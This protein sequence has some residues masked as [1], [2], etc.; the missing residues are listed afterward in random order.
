MSNTGRMRTSHEVR[1]P[2]Q[3]T[4][5]YTASGPGS[6]L[7][8]A[9]IHGW[10]LTRGDFDE[11]TEY[12]PKKYRVLAIDLA[13]HGVSRSLRDA[14]TVGEFAQ[15]VKAVLEFESASTAVVVGHSLGGAVA[16]EVGR[17]LPNVVTDIV[18]L[19]ALH[20]LSMYPAQ[21]VEH[22]EGIMRTMRDDFAAGVLGFVESGL[23]PGTDR[24]LADKYFKEMVSVRQPAGLRSLEGLARWDMDACLRATGQRITV[25]AV[26]D[27]LAQEA[28]D[29]YGDRFDI[30]PVDLGSHHFH[31]ESPERTAR[32]LV[33]AVATLDD[34]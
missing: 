24:A 6:G 20:Y 33:E 18:A 5:R 27:L 9:F 10:G 14:W 17:L 8:V 15:D 22:V 34:R 2:S 11:V 23:P 26:R 4:I 25:F 3:T 12:L 13:E 32:L 1:R 30:V 16:V 21:T 28:I 19:D 7:T 31:V 29:R